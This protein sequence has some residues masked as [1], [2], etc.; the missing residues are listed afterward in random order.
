MLPK[1][2]P[3]PAWESAHPIIVHFPIALLAFT[4][5]LVVLGLVWRTHRRGLLIAALAT[6]LVGTLGA[7][8]AV[9][10]GEAGEEA[11]E[12]IPAAAAL[13]DQ[14]EDLAEIARNIF[15]ALSAVLA[16]GVGLVL[17]KHEKLKSGV[18]IGGGVA[19][20]A[21]HSIGLLYLMAASHLGGQMVHVH[22]VR[23]MAPGGSPA[24]SEGEREERS[25]IAGALRFAAWREPEAEKKAEPAPDQSNQPTPTRPKLSDVVPAE[26]P[27]LHR[28]VAYAEGV[29][30]GAR[31]EGAAGFD[32]LQKLGFKTIISVDG[33]EP[34]VELAKTRGMR[35]VHLPVSYNGFDKAR[36]GELA[37]A[38]RDLPGPVYIHCH[39]GKHRSAAAAACVAIDLGQRDRAAVEGRMKV[40]G[41]E[42]A[43]KGLWKVVEEAKRLTK[44][45]LDAA[46]SEF[47]ERAQVSGLKRTM[48]KMED[49]YDILKTAAKNGWKQPTSGPT[50]AGLAGDI[51]DMYRALQDNP[52]VRARPDPFNPWM[53]EGE[54]LASDLEQALA[55]ELSN[56]ELN[57]RLAALTASC[58]KCH[59]KYRDD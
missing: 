45:E 6:T 26:Y 43:L 59:D 4:P 51:T 14:H 3:L 9:S 20:L 29:Y 15:I 18:T 24:A 30:S 13:L 2:P 16:L 8:L 34:A 25:F 52:R 48:V 38:V 58:K 7:I 1:P 23:S 37:R 46:G 11:A 36:Q 12:A 53:K 22:G 39:H 27:G 54:Q 56:E 49:N 10:S 33:A 47:P 17:W 28:V 42:P 57:K 55:K 41:T 5:I 21:L 44:A 40:S 50:L 32:S 35:Y 19:Y 31:P